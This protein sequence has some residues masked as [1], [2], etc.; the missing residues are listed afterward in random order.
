MKNIIMIMS[1][2]LCVLSLFGLTSYIYDN[3][4]YLLYIGVLAGL[5]GIILLIICIFL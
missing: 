3:K 5:P 1:M 2:F 4:K